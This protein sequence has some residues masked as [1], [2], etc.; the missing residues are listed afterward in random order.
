VSATDTLWARQSAWPT[1]Y[2]EI[3]VVGRE[4]DTVLLRFPQAGFPRGPDKT[5]R[6]R[7]APDGGL[8]PDEDARFVAE[9]RADWRALHG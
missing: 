1:D 3:M 4:G 2:G 5:Y 8:P 9:M 6:V 7:L